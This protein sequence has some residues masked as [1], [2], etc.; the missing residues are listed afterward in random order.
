MITVVIGQSGAG[1]TTFVKNNFLQG[2]CKIVDDIVPYTTN[3]KYCVI[4]EG[5]RDR[6]SIFWII[7]MAREMP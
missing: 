6:H 5:L 2:E 1:K 4:R 7:V 3:G